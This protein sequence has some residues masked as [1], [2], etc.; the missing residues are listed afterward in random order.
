MADFELWT[1]I[2]GNIVDMEY[3]LSSVFDK[4]G[5]N[6]ANLQ[7]VVINLYIDYGI[8]ERSQDDEYHKSTVLSL[9]KA[10]KDGRTLTLQVFETSNQGKKLQVFAQERNHDHI[11][12]WIK[13][14]MKQIKGISFKL[15]FKGPT[16][17][18]NFPINKPTV[19]ASTAS[20]A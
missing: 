3:Q 13:K 12:T 6:K 16:L 19:T 11:K 5:D 2:P 9:I 4:D 14:R 15:N 10:A 8:M 7:D 17:L 18:T 1:N 20:M